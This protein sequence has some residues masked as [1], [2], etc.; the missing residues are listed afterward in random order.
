MDLSSG[1]NERYSTAGDTVKNEGNIRRS[2]RGFLV[3]LSASYFRDGIIVIAVVR[4][5]SYRQA[6]EATDLDRMIR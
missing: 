3:S 5:P 2:R 1:L 6:F 4:T